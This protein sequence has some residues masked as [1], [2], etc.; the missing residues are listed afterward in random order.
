MLVSERA[1]SHTGEVIETRLLP[2]E[3]RDMLRNYGVDVRNGH[4][5][6]RSV[7][8]VALPEAA[9]RRRIDP[10]RLRRELAETRETT[11]TPLKEAKSAQSA[12]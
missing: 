12:L 9:A 8:P 11:G 2:A 6:W 7:T 3:D 1:D 10:Q 4:R 5:A